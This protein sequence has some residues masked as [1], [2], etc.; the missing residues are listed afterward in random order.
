MIETKV[1]KRYAKSLIDLSSETGVLDTIANDMKLL[2]SVCDQNRDLAALL[3]SPIINGDKKLSILKKV[4]ADK[5]NKLSLAFFDIITKKGRE[6]YLEAIAKEFTCQYK[7][8]KGIQTAVI[9][10]AV[11]LDDKLREEVYSIIRK[12]AQSEIEL[13]EKVDKN[14]IGGFVLRMGDKQY[15]ASIASD[16]KKL[17]REFSS[18]PYIRKN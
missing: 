2:A 12:S 13:V 18:N 17:T 5:M 4:F 7:E 11:G 16:L 6:A 9:T 10:S 15:D 1:A 3:A 14:L 8:M